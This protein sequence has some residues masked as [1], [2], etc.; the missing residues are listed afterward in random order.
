MKLVFVSVLRI[1]LS[2]LFVPLGLSFPGAS[3][4]E[5]C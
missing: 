1:S 5:T 4:G 3:W 2:A